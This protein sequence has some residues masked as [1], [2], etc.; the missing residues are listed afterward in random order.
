MALAAGTVHNSP[1]LG[2][3]VS[4]AVSFGHYFQDLKKAGTSLNPIERFV[5]SLVLANPGAPPAE[6]PSAAPQHTT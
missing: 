6:A 5:F 2:R 4:S 3:F 1:V